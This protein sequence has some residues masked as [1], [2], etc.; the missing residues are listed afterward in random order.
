MDDIIM[1]VG[2]LETTVSDIRTD[3][4]ALKATVAQLATKGEI[5][6]LKAQIGELKALISA[7]E[8]SMIKWLVGTVVSCAA[9]AFAAA[10]LIT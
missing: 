8:A 1:R 3:V 6:E 10:K 2:R 9:L 5:G 4:A 7:G